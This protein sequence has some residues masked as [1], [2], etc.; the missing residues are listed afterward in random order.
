M[1]VPSHPTTTDNSI[2]TFNTQP[3]PELRTCFPVLH[4]HSRHLPHHVIFRSP[5]PL[6]IIH[7]HRPSLTSIHEHPLYTHS[8]YLSFYSQRSSPR[9]QQHLK[10]HE[11]FP[12]T[13]YSGSRRFFCTAPFS[14]NIT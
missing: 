10:L 6:H 2:H 9:C 1:P 14:N 11:F 12:S 3:L 4:D 8:I 13:S 5:Q 7:L